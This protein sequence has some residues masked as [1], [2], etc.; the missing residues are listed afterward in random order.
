L[1]CFLST[2]KEIKL[3]LDW[4]ANTALIAD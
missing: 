4:L 3:P 2:L 1:F